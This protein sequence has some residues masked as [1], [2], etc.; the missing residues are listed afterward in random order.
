L[1]A[2]RRVPE[3]FFELAQD[4]QREALE[5]VC[6]AT[7][8]PNHLLE[9]DLWVFWTLRT[10]FASPLATDLTFKGGTSLGW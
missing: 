3:Y 2:K 1:A 5:Q 8:R 10:L 6:A 4:D 9:K 7:G